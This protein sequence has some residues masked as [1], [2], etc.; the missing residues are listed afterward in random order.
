[1]SWFSRFF[2]L[3]PR[4]PT[5]APLR[6]PKPERR[7]KPGNLASTDAANPNHIRRRSDRAVRRDMLHS[8]VREAM[9]GLDILSFQYKFKVMSVDAAGS[10]FLV[11]V[12]LSTEISLNE[13]HLHTM[14]S[15]IIA[16]ALSQRQLCINAVYW[17]MADPV[18]LGYTRKKAVQSKLNPVATSK[19]ERRATTRHKSSTVTPSGFAN[20][21]FPEERYPLRHLG[22]SQFGE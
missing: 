21:E 14:E 11:L 22:D 5:T 8:V 18:V 19:S 1:M 6:V 10:Q 12:D 16:R 20:T 2:A 9:V 17:R 13:Q 7:L 15:A 3:F 4:P